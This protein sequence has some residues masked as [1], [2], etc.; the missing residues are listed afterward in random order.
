MNTQTAPIVITNSFNKALFILTTTAALVMTL[1]ISQPVQAK[2]EGIQLTATQQAAIG[3]QTQQAIPVK[4]VPLGPFTAFAQ[5]ALNKRFLLTT[6]VEGQVIALPKFHGTL[7]A[8][9]LVAQIKSPTLLTL[10]KSYLETLIDLPVAEASLKR[11]QKLQKQGVAS[12]KQLMES[13]AKVQKLKKAAKIQQQQ[14]LLAGFTPAQ[15]RQIQ[16]QLKLLPPVLD[17]T[18]PQTGFL[19]QTE[20]KLGERLTADSPIAKLVQINPIILVTKVPAE[21][22]SQLTVG[23]L[24]KI[25]TLPNLTGKVEL[26]EKFADPLT[27]SFE[28]H[29][30]FDNPNTQ[31]QPGIQYHLTFLKPAT[32]HTFK[33]PQSA[34]SK[35]NDSEVVFVKGH[36][37]YL[38]KAVQ[39]ATIYDGEAYFQG[40]QLKQV[41]IVTK[42]TVALKTIME[43]EGEE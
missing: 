15:I 36:Q 11:V 40:E 21:T 1:F 38:V 19:Y 26:I 24:A 7:T 32:P 18:A 30:E 5:T 4:Q 34:L 8:G 37:G 13:E 42:G 39:V 3:I 12:L 10:Q 2:E 14:L 9:E 41:Q 6:P 23:Q 35:M 17:I 29:V 43:G 22:A 27:Q 31:I 33:S 20:V 16:Q 28:I 25:D